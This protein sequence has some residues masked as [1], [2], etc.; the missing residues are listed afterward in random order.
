MHVRCESLYTVSWCL[1]SSWSPFPPDRS[2]SSKYLKIKYKLFSRAQITCHFYAIYWHYPLPQ[3]PSPQ[4]H[5]TH[6]PHQLFAPPDTLCPSILHVPLW[7]WCSLANPSLVFVVN[8]SHAA[9]TSTHSST[10][11][12]SPP[13]GPSKSHLLLLYV[14]SVPCT[15]LWGCLSNSVAIIYTYMSVL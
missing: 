14:T 7:C 10:S 4:P 12:K 5:L 15:N 9:K 8:L 3:Q 6:Q 1:W 2:R 11:R 13:I